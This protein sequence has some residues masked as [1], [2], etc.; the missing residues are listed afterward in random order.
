[1]L[2]CFEDLLDQI[3]AFVH[4]VEKVIRKIYKF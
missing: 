1:M 3:V 4:V 2:D